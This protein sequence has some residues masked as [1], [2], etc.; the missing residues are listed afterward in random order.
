MWGTTPTAQSRELTAHSPQPPQP[1]THSTAHSTQHTAHSTQHTAHSTQHTAHNPVC[2]LLLG[3]L[4]LP[5][6]SKLAVLQLIQTLRQDWSEKQARVQSCHENLQALENR[7][8]EAKE[9]VA[10]EVLC[11]G[12]G[13]LYGAAAFCL[14][15]VCTIIF[16]LGF[17]EKL[18][19]LR[20]IS[21]PPS[22]LN[23]LEGA[24]ARRARAG[25]LFGPLL[26]QSPNPR[27]D[28]FWLGIWTG[29]F[30]WG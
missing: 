8:V 15:F 23:L 25:H 29:P 26:I 9:A 13:G 22:V 10:T 20:K 17:S 12:Q 30:S 27:M 5:C 24:S 11:A 19:D 2:R 7:L 14:L 28:P 21:P 4:C 3:L 1:T 18:F 16:C 6:L